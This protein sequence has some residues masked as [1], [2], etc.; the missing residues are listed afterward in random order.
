MVTIKMEDGSTFYLLSS[1][2]VADAPAMEDSD[3]SFESFA[4]FIEEM[5]PWGIGFT[6]TCG[7]AVGTMTWG[8][9]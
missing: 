8:D 4:A 1:G 7:D 2:E 5:A 9:D 6:L 3:L